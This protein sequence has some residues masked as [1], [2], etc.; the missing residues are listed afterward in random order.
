MSIP[1]VKEVEGGGISALSCSI[2][3]HWLLRAIIPS[4]EVNPF[5]QLVRTQGCP[6]IISLWSSTASGHLE[7]SQGVLPSP[8]LSCHFESIDID[9]F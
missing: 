5:Q 2:V 1:F 7:F 6:D 8:A 9:S 4:F 3:L